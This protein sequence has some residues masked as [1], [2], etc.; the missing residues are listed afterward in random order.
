MLIDESG[1]TITCPDEDGFYLESCSAYQKI[2]N[3]NVA[4]VECVIRWKKDRVFFIE[5]KTTAPDKDSQ[6]KLNDYVKRIAAKYENSIA[7]CYAMLHGILAFDSKYPI[8]NRLKECL[9]NSPKI[10]FML[11]VRNIDEVNC[12]LLAYMLNKELRPTLKIWGAEAVIVK[13]GVQA[14]KKNIVQL[15]P[16]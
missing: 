11:I 5:A 9:L 13:S 1:M 3:H 4:A 8:G 7:M 10:R 12:P 2:C 15:N 16:A 6:E 14:A